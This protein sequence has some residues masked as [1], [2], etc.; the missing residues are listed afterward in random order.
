MGK[1]TSQI[2]SKDMIDS[3]NK[4]NVDA[5]SL[6][7]RVGVVETSLAEKATTLTGLIK[8][9]QKGEITKIKLF[10]DSITEGVGATNHVSPPP[11]TQ[12]KIFDDGA[13]NVFYEAQYTA[14]SWGNFFREYVSANFSSVSFVNAGVAGKSA[15]WANAN[16]QYWVGTEDVAFVMLGTND[17]WDNTDL[18][19]YKNDLTSFL[20][21]VKARSNLM[22]VMTATPTLNDFADDAGTTPNPSY[23]FG[24]KEVDRVITE[25]CSENG[26]IHFSHYRKMLDYAYNTRTPLST[27]LQGR[28]V[29]SHPVDAGHKYMWYILQK[30]LGFIDN[31]IKWDGL[32]N[33]PLYSTINLAFDYSTLATDSRFTFFDM[34]YVNTIGFSDPNIAQYPE[35]KPGLLR[36]Y[37][38]DNI[39]YVWQEYIIRVSSQIYRRYWD[40]NTNT[41]SSWTAVISSQAASSEYSTVSL[42][43][44]YAS[45]ANDTMFTQFK[46]IYVATIS[47]SDPNLAHYPESASGYLRMF[48]GENIAYVWEEYLLRGGSQ[49]YRRYW[50][51]NTNTWTP[52]TALVQTVPTVPIKFANNTRLATDAITA[53]TANNIE[54]TDIGASNS[55]IAS[56]PTGATGTLITYRGNN[57]LY[58]YQEYHLRQGLSVYKRFWDTTNTVWT[59]WTKISAV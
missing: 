36:M 31:T 29:G 16:K 42:T 54:Y 53:Y 26:Y 28:T 40:F 46:T 45:L 21:Y 32:Q 41:W 4:A 7:N 13:G 49:V 22:I 8:K 25:V 12:L 24:M 14:R 50:D 1:V 17:R 9:I 56:F 57:D 11:N 20:S 52:W 27:L 47:A 35:S 18:A 3:K 2:M 59:T 6:N 23:K 51:F 30:E 15:K 19:G 33:V 43:F 5:G 39:A 48:R 34:F 37:R 58:N 10:G 55:T 38:G 44:S